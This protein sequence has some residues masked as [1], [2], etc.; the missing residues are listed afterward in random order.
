MSDYLHLDESA[1]WRREHL[2]DEA[3]KRRLIAQLPAQPVRTGVRL[4]RAVRIRLAHALFALASW[5]S[6]DV[7]APA[8]TF[9]LARARR[10]NGTV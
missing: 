2:L 9:E 5:L 7:G 8:R 1:R 10:R 6:P 4:P 3:K